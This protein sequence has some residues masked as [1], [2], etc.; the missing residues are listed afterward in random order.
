MKKKV[1][2]IKGLKK[3]PMVWLPGSDALPPGAVKDIVLAA[4][5]NGGW[6]DLDSPAIFD[7]MK[8]KLSDLATAFMILSDP[9]HPK[10]NWACLVEKVYMGD[11]HYLRLV[12]CIPEPVK[13]SWETSGPP[14]HAASWMSP[15]FVE[16]LFS[17]SKP[18]AKKPPAK[19]TKKAPAPKPTSV[20][21]ELDKVA[22]GF[23]ARYWPKSP[24]GT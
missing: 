3:C 6:L 22:D 24:W 13:S 12:N 9:K 21:Q 20:D 19:K 11:R 15:S 10:N 16:S 4:E 7:G 23:V 18:S 14:S 8:Y 5:E 2:K 1:S 17:I